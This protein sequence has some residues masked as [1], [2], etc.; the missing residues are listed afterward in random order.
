MNM[1][2]GNSCCANFAV[3]SA[4]LTNAKHQKSQQGRADHG[5]RVALRLLLRYVFKTRNALLE[6]L[7]I[8]DGKFL[9]NYF[10]GYI[11]PR[12]FSRRYNQ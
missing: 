5:E 9:C 2:S 6:F 11:Q 1:R 3:T 4:T 8:H 10:P 12:F 7:V